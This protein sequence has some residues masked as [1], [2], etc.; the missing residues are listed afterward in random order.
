MEYGPEGQSQLDRAAM[1]EVCA[2]GVGVEDQPYL[3]DPNEVS[4]DDF[5]G[6]L[7]GALLN[8]GVEDPETYLRDKGILE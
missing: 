4:D 8:N 3:A 5:I 1:L 7:F 6:A 2:D